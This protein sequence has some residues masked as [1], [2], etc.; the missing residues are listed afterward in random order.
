MIERQGTV[1]PKP[2]VWLRT[3]LILAAAVSAICFIVNPVEAQTVGPAT[4]RRR[5]SSTE[6]DRQNDCPT[7]VLR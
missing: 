3:R 6:P 4:Q 1:L 5:Q 7:V 2:D